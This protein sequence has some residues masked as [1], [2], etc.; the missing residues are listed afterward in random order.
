M[1]GPDRVVAVGAGATALALALFAIAHEPLVAL[2]ASVVAGIAWIAVLSNLNVSAQVALP[3]W[4]RARGLSVFVTIFFG[5]MAIGSVIW[6]QLATMLGLRAALLISAAGAALAVPLTWR[7][8][9]QTAAGLD[10]TPSMHWPEPVVS[11]QIAYDR[12]PVMVTVEYRID[13]TRTLAFVAAMNEVAAERRRDG[14]YDWG[15]FEDAGQPGRWLEYFLVESWLEHRRQHERV[16]KADA[17]MQVRA[18]A[19]HVGE[20]PPVVVHWL[21]PAHDGQEGNAP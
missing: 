16:T 18:Q 9:L 15:L 13:P 7:W 1:L 8:K 17:D 21:A 4:V 10:M 5:A 12:G 11:S 6:G 20:T 14:A 19:F 2:A 3:D